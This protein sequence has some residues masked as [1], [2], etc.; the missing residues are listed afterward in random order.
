MALHLNLYHEIH[1]QA[2]RE[3]RDPV[4]LAGLAGVI[5]L[6]FLVAW[7]SYR[8]SVVSAVEAKRNDLKSTWNK[9]EPQMKTAIENEVR[10]LAQQKSN[11]SLVERLQER[12]YWAPFLDTFAACTP[13]HIQLISLTGDVDEGKE[14]KKKTITVLVRGVAAGVQPR[15]AAEDFRRSLQ[16]KLAGLYSEVSVGFDA[17][18][19]EDGVETVKLNGQTL[20]TATF[21]I[22]VQ[23][24]PKPAQ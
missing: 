1:R 17:N 6:V 23:F 4:K 15:T 7:Y 9:V 3:R 5:F 12:F 19:L 24:N 11:Q 2:E 13:S 20:G 8:L 10:F 18:S 14:K 21:R 16:D 22:R